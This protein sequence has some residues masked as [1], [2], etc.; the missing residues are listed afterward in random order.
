MSR[1]ANDHFSAHSAQYVSARPTYPAELFERLAGLSPSNSY[2]W[3]CG[4]G[5]GQ[6]AMALA[7]HFCRVVGSDMSE[8]Q[9]GQ[10][11]THPRVRYCVTLA[12]G[13]CFPR[14]YF[15]LVVVAQALHW[16]NID[17]FYREI[18][19]VTKPR[20]VL[21]AWCY[22]KPRINSAI[23]DVVDAFYTNTLDTYWSP[24]RKHVEAGYTTLSFPFDE[25]AM[26]AYSIEQWWDLDQ[27]ARYVRSWSAT[28]RYMKSRSEDPVVPLVERLAGIWGAPREKHLVTWPMYL[29]VGR[30]E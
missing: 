13:S 4:T 6:A 21:A 28:Q 23:D 1:R 18:E 26:P 29:R 3:D 27:W 16:F 22:Q 12:E 15:D 11:P 20:G 9:I 14:H 5:N 8:N 17:E 25:I 2:A 24:E 7:D 10:A 19:R 30:L